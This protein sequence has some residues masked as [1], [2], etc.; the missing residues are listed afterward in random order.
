[1]KNKRLFP[2]LLLCL[3]LPA[4]SPLLA[5]RQI[6]DMAGRS[7]TVPDEIRRV[8][9]IGHVIPVVA[10]VAPD[11]LANNYRLSQQAR[12]FLPD[13]LHQDKVI[14]AI[15]SRVLSDEEIMKLAPDLIIMESMPYTLAHAGRVQQRLNIPVVLVDQKM[16][17]YPESFSFLGELLGRP[18]QAAAMTAYVNRHLYPRVQR[19]ASLPAD[20]RVRVYYAEDP[21]GLATNPAGSIHTEVLDLAGGINVAQVEKLPNE[22]TNPVSLEQLYLWQPDLI[23][24]WTPGADQLTTWKAIMDNPLWQQLTAV[25]N[26]RVVQIPWLPYSWFD[27]P[28]GS[29]RIPGTLWLAHLLYPELFAD[30]DL[31]AALQEYFRIFYHRDLSPAEVDE[32]LQLADPQA[33]RNRRS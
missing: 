18:E 10:A 13:I 15:G 26:G 30:L 32:L 12:R 6:T 11:K 31:V 21:D 4:S 24:V 19:A 5:A 8:Y 2:W 33:G 28:P 1:M 22:G 17:R 29:N 20:Q 14:P 9:A 3:L 7:L 27:R 25:A 23:L 16:T